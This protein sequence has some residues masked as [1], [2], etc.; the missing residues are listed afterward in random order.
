MR[1]RLLR[2][3]AYF[4]L[5][6]PQKILL[7]FFIIF[8][9][10]FFLTGRLQF[11]P[12]FLKLFPAEEGPIRLYMENLKETGAFDLLFILLESKEGVDP[13]GLIEL[14][15]TI[16]DKLK[17]MEVDGQKAFRSIRFQKVEQEDLEKAKP[18]L[19]LF[20]THPYLFL[21]EGDIEKLQKKWTEEAISRQVQKNK[22]ILLSHASFVMK[23]LIQTDP[24]ELRWL[25][26]EKWKEGMKGMEFDESS[27]FFL[28]R[29]QKS[30]LLI[31]EPSRP[32]TDF[33]FSKCLMTALEKLKIPEQE[34]PIKIYLTGAHPIATAEAKVL[35]F[36]MQSSFL[37][38]L[39]L[40]LI[41]FFYVY[42][43][44]ITLLIIGLPLIGGIQLTMGIASLTLGSLNI[45]TIAFAAILVGLGIDFAIH[46][47]DRYH[48]ERALGENISSAIETTLTETGSG[49]W[50]GAFT[51]IF[52][53]IVL[54]FS[55][56]RG[57]TELAFL[58]SAGLLCSL[59][60]TYFVLPSFLVWMDQRKK[61]YPYSALKT[62]SFKSTSI[63]IEKHPLPIFLG[64]IGITL[65]LGFLSLRIEV[66]KD[67]RN[68]RPKE[69]QPLEV[70]D[71]MGRAFGGKRLEG[72]SVHEGSE[73]QP[74]LS[75]E[76][77]WNRVLEKYQRGGRIDSFYSISKL[78]PSPEKQKRVANLIRE[79]IDLE[80]VKKNFIKALK[81]NGFDVGGFQSLIQKIDELKR[82][83]ETVYSPEKLINLFLESPFKKGI[84]PFLFKKGDTY[85]VLSRI[86]YRKGTLS[87]AQLEKEFSGIS[88]TSPE[89]VELEIL[90]IVRED[91]YLLTPIAFLMVFLLVVLHFRNWRVTLF[92][93]S[94]LTMG[95]VWM[96]GMMSVFGIKINFVNAVILPM[97][98]GMGIDNSIH[99]MHRYLEERNN[100]AGHA[101]RTTGRAMT[102]CSFT[103]ML[104]FGSLATARYQAI[105]TMGWVTIFGMG[106]CLMTALF[107]LP[108]LLILWKGKHGKT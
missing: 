6:H 34:N 67:F 64:F 36:D 8:G 66:E 62:F 13:N 57:I 40:V 20:L 89:R 32:A 48:Q 1:R 69:I 12:D 98:I 95:L 71:R 75:K 74:L 55:R 53:F 96:V 81:E 45:L 77:Q 31:T 28:S 106:F 16:A 78:I 94:P 21:D 85:R 79:S 63:F 84:E 90:R 83:E 59:L 7:L 97:I 44:W 108:T 52:A 61:S 80:G 3:I 58:V 9:L 10:A 33:R 4:C 49:I 88:I 23:G 102:L 27:N 70:F 37:I 38:S 103:T 68:L 93:L 17:E 35:R 2:R 82:G 72:I 51:T 47:Y 76:E 24:F 54:F 29:D 41:L 56:V 107:F 14:G 39:V 86:Y 22:K 46:L 91:L 87:L 50:T 100:D 101:L 11:D 5:H 25:F 26:M 43:R 15:R 42:R 18:V 19:N 65:L 30:L 73:I 99:L 60:C 105:S 92:I 104:G